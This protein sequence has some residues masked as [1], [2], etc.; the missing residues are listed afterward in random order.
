MKA[1][2]TNTSNP[3]EGSDTALPKLYLT[4]MKITFPNG[5]SIEADTLTDVFALYAMQEK[6]VS[7]NIKQPYK[8]DLETFPLRERYRQEYGKRFTMKSRAGL[9]INFLTALHAAGWPP[10]GCKMKSVA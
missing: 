9:A 3:W 6:P 4:K 10:N 5:L 8:G 1:T 2:T 7:P